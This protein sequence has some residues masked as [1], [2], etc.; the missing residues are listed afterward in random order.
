MGGLMWWI[1]RAN[2][3]LLSVG[4][5]LYDRGIADIGLPNPQLTK[6]EAARL[7][8]TGESP[9]RVRLVKEPK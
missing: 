2:G 1:E 8:R 5:V 3:N 7:C 9:V 4:R 6:R